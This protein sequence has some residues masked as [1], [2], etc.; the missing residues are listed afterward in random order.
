MLSGIPNDV[1]I[2]STNRVFS[3]EMCAWWDQYLHKSLICL[4]TIITG[5]ALLCFWSSNHTRNICI[6]SIHQWALRNHYLMQCTD[7]LKYVT[8][9]KK[10]TPF[11]PA[12]RLLFCVLSIKKHCDT[13]PTIIN[14]QTINMQ[15]LSIDPS[16]TIRQFNY[17]VLGRINHLQCHFSH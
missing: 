5:E 6:P 3:N 4:S 15:I 1:G 16:I 2:N 9:P 10:T 12:D 14:W 17:R 8:I 7:R 13:L 11:G